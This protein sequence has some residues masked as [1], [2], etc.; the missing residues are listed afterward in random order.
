MIAEAV[1]YEDFWFHD[2][3]WTE[4]DYLRIPPGGPKI[5]LVDGRLVVS[6]APRQAHQR[7]MRRLA[8]LLEA[9]APD[10]LAVEVA[11]NVRIG[12]EKILVPDVVATYEQGDDVL[13][14]DPAEILL[15]VEVLSPS[16][17]HLYSVARI[18]WYLLVEVDEN[19]EGPTIVLQRLGSGHYN[20]VARATCG[21]MLKLPDPFGE[22]DPGDLLKRRP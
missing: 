14:H 18:P 16:N 20:E 7:L 1:P 11:L 6:P 21:Q 19:D 12:P 5:E 10:D 2:G 22:L 4:E 9:Q 8:N 15:V 3:P 17:N 13:V